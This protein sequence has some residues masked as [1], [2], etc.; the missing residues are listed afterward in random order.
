[1]DGGTTKPSDDSGKLGGPKTATGKLASAANALKHGLT[2]LRYV[3]KILEAERFEQ[4]RVELTEEYAPATVTEQFLVDEMARHAA[5]LGVAARGE[6]ASFRHHARE[7]SGVLLQTQ[8]AEGV[9]DA[10]EDAILSGAM[11]SEK[12]ASFHRYRRGHEKAYYAALKKLAELQDVRR[13]GELPVD[14]TDRRDA[15]EGFATEEECET[16]LRR[17]FEKP[18]WECPSCR[19]D[20]GHWLAR[21]KVW[22]CADCHRQVGLRAGTIMARSP[23]PLVQWFATV[24]LL[25]KTSE[26]SG[27]DLARATGIRRHA[28]ARRMAAKVRRAMASKDKGTL[29]AGLDRLHPR[30]S[31]SSASGPNQRQ[32]P[33]E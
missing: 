5:M 25:L 16:H 17:R 18:E 2:S 20:K 3:P 6:Q 26:T 8:P 1:M 24:R 7:V 29:L 28:T 14:S 9:D 13:Q 22:Q 21:R 4:V 10:V 11:S 30:P 19:C 15:D 27:A 31:G 12:L 32:R 23:L 33:A